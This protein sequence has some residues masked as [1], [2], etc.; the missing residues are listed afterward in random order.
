[1]NDTSDIDPTLE[2]LNKN[3]NI[4]GPITRNQLTTLIYKAYKRSLLSFLDHTNIIK[5]NNSL[6][7]LR[8]VSDLETKLKWD[9]EIFKDPLLRRYLIKPFD[10]TTV[11]LVDNLYCCLHYPDQDLEISKQLARNAN[12]PEAMK[13]KDLRLIAG[14][15]APPMMFNSYDMVREKNR[16]MAKESH[17]FNSVNLHEYYCYY[18]HIIDEYL[19]NHS[20]FTNSKASLSYNPRLNL[21]IYLGNDRFRVVQTKLEQWV[22]E[23]YVKRYAEKS[24]RVLNS[25][26]YDDN[27]DKGTCRIC[28]PPTRNNIEIYSFLDRYINQDIPIGLMKDN[29]TLF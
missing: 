20:T 18:P 11:S 13:Y 15:K 10:N 14:V 7:G 24:V 2:K 17:L 25:L 29:F 12:K 27:P 9:N 21:F 5:V 8:M 22:W 23:Q 26:I 3:P 1:M 6:D 4:F 19:I 16:I 28:V